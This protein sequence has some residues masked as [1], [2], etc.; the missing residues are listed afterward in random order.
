MRRR[1]PTQAKRPMVRLAN[2]FWL[3]NAVMQCQ[4]R[5]RTA[6]RIV[7]GESW[8]K[9]RSDFTQSS[10]RVH[11][12][13]REAHV[14]VMQCVLDSRLSLGHLRPL[15]HCSGLGSRWRSPLRGTAE[16]GQSISKTASVLS[17]QPCKRLALAELHRVKDCCDLFLDMT[18]LATYGHDQ[19]DN[20]SLLLSGAKE[21]F[22][23]YT[24]S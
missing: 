12:K 19:A 11:V 17:T 4:R 7:V 2:W 13:M 9:R 24:W 14:G 22:S 15:Y 1:R 8:R 21:S 6:E 18:I 23:S 16:A 5:K 10:L 20:G 3:M